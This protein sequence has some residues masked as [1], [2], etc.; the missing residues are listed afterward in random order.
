MVQLIAI[1]FYQVERMLKKLVKN[2]ISKKEKIFNLVI[3]FHQLL[4]FV[5]REFYSFCQF[6]EGLSEDF[7]QFADAFVTQRC[8]WAG[9][10]RAEI[11]TLKQLKGYLQGERNFG[12]SKISSRILLL[13]VFGEKF[14]QP[15][16]CNK[17]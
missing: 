14:T 15:K 6:L 1:L 17:T 16:I 9:R 2:E 10:I 12:L 5:L 7:G 8:I 13:A 11:I 4:D 3:K